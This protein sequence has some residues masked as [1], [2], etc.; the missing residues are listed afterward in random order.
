MLI[1]YSSRRDVVYGTLQG[2]AI[3]FKHTSEVVKSMGE[4]MRRTREEADRRAPD[5]Q[6]HIWRQLQC[7]ILEA[8][9]NGIAYTRDIRLQREWWDRFRKEGESMLGQQKQA[10][11]QTVR[12]ARRLAA[13]CRMQVWRFGSSTRARFST[14]MGEKT[15]RTR[16]E[17]ARRAPDMQIHSWRQLQGEILE[18]KGH[19]HSVYS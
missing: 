3:R 19:G 6:I 8:K 18:A 12:D 17:A 2:L 4:K 16:E 9:G 13:G 10:V 7:G 11:E 15:R 1:R 5:M 14:G